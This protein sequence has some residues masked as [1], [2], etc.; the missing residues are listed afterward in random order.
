MRFLVLIP[1]L[2]VHDNLVHCFVCKMR[3]QSLL[4]SFALVKLWPKW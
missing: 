3:L 1:C 2:T 4:T